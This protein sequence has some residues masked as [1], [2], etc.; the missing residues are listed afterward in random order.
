MRVDLCGVGSLE[1]L[2]DPHQVPSPQKKGA[3][4]AKHAFLVVERCAM[5]VLATEYL[6]RAWF[7]SALATF[8]VD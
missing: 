5:E 1:G 8:G 6:L 2:S 3:S 4:L 7:H